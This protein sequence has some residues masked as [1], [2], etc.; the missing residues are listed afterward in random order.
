M[1]SDAVTMGGLAVRGKSPK[2][3]KCAFWTAAKEEVCGGVLVLRSLVGR[4]DQAL[5]VGK[6]CD[7]DW[8]ENRRLEKRVPAV[9]SMGRALSIG[10]FLWKA[11]DSRIPE[12]WGFGGIHGNPQVESV[13]Q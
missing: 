8:A 5:V 11:A 3:S 1:V 12:G 9:D 7:S 2:S 6:E 10:G 13:G 4:W